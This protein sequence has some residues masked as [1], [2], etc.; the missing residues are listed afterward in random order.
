MQ[1]ERVKELLGDTNQPLKNIVKLAGFG[2]LE[3]LCR[4]FKRA[5]GLTLL[6]HRRQ[7]Q[8]D[9]GSYAGKLLLL[10][11]LLIPARRDQ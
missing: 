11:D 4:T 8:V 10:N 2:R 1:L 3:T 9:D 6:E 7:Q 5:T